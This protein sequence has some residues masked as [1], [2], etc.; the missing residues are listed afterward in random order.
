[1]SESTEVETLQPPR[2]EPERFGPGDPPSVLAGVGPFL[3][4]AQAQNAARGGNRGG[5]GGM[6]NFTIPGLE[7]FD[8]P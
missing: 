4:A 3:A 7:G 8:N 1:M 2:V 6:G 5:G